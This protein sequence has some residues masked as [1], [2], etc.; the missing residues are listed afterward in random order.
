M[1]NACTLTFLQTSVNLIM[2]RPLQPQSRTIKG[3]VCS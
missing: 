2:T 3:T 1:N